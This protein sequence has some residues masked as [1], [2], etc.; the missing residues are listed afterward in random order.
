MTPPLAPGDVLASVRREIER[1]AVRARNG[2][3]HVTGTEW[4]PPAPTPSE[5]VWREG[6]AQLRR[7][8]GGDARLGTPVL[9]FLGLV[10][11]AYVFDLVAG[12]ASSGA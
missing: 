7:Y 2:I 3:K 1:N 9:A 8:R 12:T 11:R 5:T 6:K 10:S 4:A